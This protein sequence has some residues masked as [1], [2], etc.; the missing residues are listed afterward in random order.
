MTTN[1]T[2]PGRTTLADRLKRADDIIDRRALG[3][4]V[5]DIDAQDAAR[6][7]VR[8]YRDDWTN[9]PLVEGGEGRSGSSVASSAGQFMLVLAVLLLL[10]AIAFGMTSQGLLFTLA[11]LSSAAC[12]CLSLA[13]GWGES[14]AVDEREPL[15]LEA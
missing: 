10:V 6:V 7:K 1:G 11:L 9:W 8:A 4:V 2:V 15:D 3:R 12:A 13:C 14:G 5:D